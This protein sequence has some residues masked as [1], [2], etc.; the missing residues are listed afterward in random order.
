MPRDPASFRKA[1]GK[2][3]KVQSPFDQFYLREALKQGNVKAL[4]DK[5]IDLKFV[6]GSEGQIQALK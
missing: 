2:T 1:V 5:M 6:D 4:Y 3:V